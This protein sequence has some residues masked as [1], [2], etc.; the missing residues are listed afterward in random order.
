MY[1]L[2]IAMRKVKAVNVVQAC[3]LALAA[4]RLV[5]NAEKEPVLNHE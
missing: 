2:Q 3:A 5:S 4:V 1:D